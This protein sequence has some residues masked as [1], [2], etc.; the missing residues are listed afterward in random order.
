VV[1]FHHVPVETL[2]GQTAQVKRGLW[3][4]R[5]ERPCPRWFL[6]RIS[7]IRFAPVSGAVP[8]IPPRLRRRGPAGPGDFPAA[9]PPSFGVS[10]AVPGR[11]PTRARFTGLGFAS[12]R[13]HRGTSCRPHPLRL[14]SAGPF[15]EG[16]EALTSRGVSL[17][18]CVGLTG[19]ENPRNYFFYRCS[20]RGPGK[21][22]GATPPRAVPP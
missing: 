4:L 10:Q 21:K 11:A 14:S 5:L 15:F 20:G 7:S 18:R 1:P 19:T 16:V 8:P 9:E 3:F 17:F 13:E 12:R 2:S 22:P 6:F